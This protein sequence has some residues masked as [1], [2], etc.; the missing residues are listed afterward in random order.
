M[1]EEVKNIPGLDPE[2]VVVIRKFGFKSMKK[3]RNRITIDVINDPVTG[4]SVEKPSFNLGDLQLAMFVYGIENAPFFKLE[5]SD[6][7]KFDVVDS[8]N[9]DTRIVDYLYPKIAALNNVAQI[10]MLKKKIKLVLKGR[11]RDREANEVIHRAIMCKMFR[12]TPKE[13]DE[14]DYEDIVLFEQV[15]AEV[16]DKNPLSLLM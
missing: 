16:A 11:S 6:Q 13:L 2:S 12:C 14:I 10:D 9:F 4:Q 5:M 7:E 1:E 15:Y 3:I 8:D